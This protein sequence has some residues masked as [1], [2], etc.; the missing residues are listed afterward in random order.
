MVSTV[1]PRRCKDGYKC[2]SLCIPNCSPR[3]FFL[4]CHYSITALFNGLW[5]PAS[6]GEC[7]TSMMIKRKVENWDKWTD[8]N[9]VFSQQQHSKGG[10]LCVWGTWPSP[11]LLMK[12]KNLNIGIVWNFLHKSKYASWEVVFA[13]LPY[14]DFIV[15]RGKVLN[16]RNPTNC[17]QSSATREPL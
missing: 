13:H 12:M 15:Q 1:M 11:V 5:L 10:N 8:Y 4:Q 16:V 2:C 17:I 9:M 3:E 6:F 14:E 7:F